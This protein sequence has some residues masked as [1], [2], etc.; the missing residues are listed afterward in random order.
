MTQSPR[1]QQHH[2]GTSEIGTPSYSRERCCIRIDR[3]TAPSGEIT[4]QRV[5]C[6]DSK[7]TSDQVDHPYGSY[8]GN[9]TYHPQCASCYLGHAHSLNYHNAHTDNGQKSWD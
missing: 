2:Y 6:L 4:P 5:F 3:Y 9:M 8:P 7:D 1:I